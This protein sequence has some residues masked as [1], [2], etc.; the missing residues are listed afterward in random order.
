[1]FQDNFYWGAASSAYQIEGAAFI[2]GKGKS[3][4]DVVSNDGNLV[5]GGQTGHVACDH[6]HRYEEDVAIM[7]EIGLNAYRLSFSWPRILPNGTGQVNPKGLDFYDRLI[8]K[9]LEN[10]IEPFV[11]IFH[12]DYPWEL[13]LKGGWLNPD[14]PKWFAEYAS[15]VSNHFKDRVKHWITINEPQCFVLLGH[16]EGKHAPGIK[17]PVEAILTA[18]HNVNL[19]HGRAVQAIR[20]NQKDARIGYSPVG[21]TFYP[22]NGTE[23]EILWAKKCMFESNDQTLWNNGWWMDP[24]FFGKYPE[25]GLKKFEK[26]MPRITDEDLKIISQPLDFFGCNIYH[27]APVED[28]GGVMETHK[29]PV[30]NPK[31]DMGWNVTPESLYWGPKFLY[32][33]YRKP[34]IITENGAAFKDWVM[35]DG[36]VHDYERID[37]LARYISNLRKAASE[38]VEVA[39]YFLWSILDN[40]EWEYGYEK[41]F[42]ITY[43]EFDTQ[44]RVLKDSAYWYKKVIKS[45]GRDLSLAIE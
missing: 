6:Y 39:G 20:S 37:F 44:K 41:R 40:F 16:M 45:N 1:M 28:N 21:T 30:G 17:Y 27:G 43:V 38:G 29:H 34:I 42:G 36:R 26:F 10:N 8:N 11:T 33:R 18:I 25:E 35:S 23:K 24:I 9:L 12:W 4:W 2:D 3:V 5:Y 14:S 13:F 32:E 31:T 7:K 19:A 22:K 15:V